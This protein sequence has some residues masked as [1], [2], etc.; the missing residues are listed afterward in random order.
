MAQKLLLIDEN[1]HLL[2]LVGDYLANLGYEVHRA[3]ESD[4]AEALFKNYHYSVVVSG[5]NW[6]N[7][8]GS[9]KTLN[10]YIEELIYH[11]RIVR[12]E[13]PHSEPCAAPE[14]DDDAPLVIEKPNSLLLLRDLNIRGGQDAL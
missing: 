2:T 1:C 11:P 8:A 13:E 10:Q 7:F 14:P 9:G 4:E 6:E 12:L 5:A 3:S